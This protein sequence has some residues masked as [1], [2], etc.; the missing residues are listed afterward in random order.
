MKIRFMTYNIQHGMDHARYMEDR[1]HVIDL[2]LVADVIR[3]YQPDVVG[4]NEVR[5]RGV[6]PEYREQTKTI[7]DQLGYEHYY[8]AKAIDINGEGPYGNAVLSKYPMRRAW[9]VPIPDPVYKTGGRGFETRC[10]LKVAFDV[11][12]RFDVLISHFGLNPSEQR[13][14]VS[15]LLQLTESRT[16]PTV[17]MGDL[18]MEPDDPTMQPIFRAFLDTAAALPPDVKS[19][20]SERPTIK[21]D[22]VFATD[23]FQIAAAELPEVVASDHCPYIADLNL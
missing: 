16:A 14:A 15:M 2:G 3:R 6:H 8:F 5:D 19:F 12:A 23:E 22:Y 20:P 17:F 10:I 13:N 4:L 1:S 11:P 9:T 18:N 21:I 7:A